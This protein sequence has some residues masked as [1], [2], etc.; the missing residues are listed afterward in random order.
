MPGVVY[1]YKFIKIFGRSNDPVGFANTT[2]N[3][4]YTGI[5][6]GG[7]L[8]IIF[9]DGSTTTNDAQNIVRLDGT[10]DASDIGRGWNSSSV[11]TPMGEFNSRDWADDWHHFRIYLRFNSGTTAETESPDGALYLEIDGKIYADVGGLYNRHYYNSLYLR[12]DCRFS[13]STKP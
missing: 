2:F 13:D 1:G 3:L 12:G 10:T 4:D 9:G 8:S 6:D 11:N 5:D 7:L